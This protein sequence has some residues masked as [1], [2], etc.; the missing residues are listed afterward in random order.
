MRDS[1]RGKVAVVAGASRGCGRGIALALGDAGTTVYVTGRTTRKG[2]K[3]V[4]GAPGTIEDTADEVTRRGG[5]GIPVQV[6]H[7]N[8]AQVE[9]F[10]ARVKRE[11][12]R[13]DILACAVWGGNER[14]ADPVWQEPFWNQPVGAW[15]EFMGGGPQA[16]WIAAHAA[17]GLMAQQRAGL[18]VAI[19]EPMIETTRFSGSLQW[20]LFEH[21]PHYSLNRLVVTLAPGA[22]TAG[23]AIIG[24]LPGFMKTER[25]EMHMQGADEEAR[26]QYRY[27]LAESTEYSGRAVAALAADPN[28]MSK[29]GELVFVADAAKEYGFTDIDGRYIDNFYRVLGMIQP[30]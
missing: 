7:S 15:E 20:D 19:S 5:H 4:D 3:A 29:A 2:P 24:L 11:H 12:G 27:D 28:V 1:L 16:F 17:A 26:K 14:H 6:D 23:I 22:R 18:I 21:L 8:A 30:A 9:E 13:L 10:L 25:V